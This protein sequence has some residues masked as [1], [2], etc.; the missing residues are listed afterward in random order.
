MG[1]SALDIS[2]WRQAA[3]SGSVI[4]TKDSDFLRLALADDSGPQVVLIRCGNL[5]LRPFRIWLAA[6]LPQMISEL[7]AGEKVVELI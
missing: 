3:Q 5:A 4:L 7:S 2:I 6:R 1:S